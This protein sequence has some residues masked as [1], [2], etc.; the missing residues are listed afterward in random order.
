MKGIYGYTVDDV[1]DVILEKYY[2][3]CK[4][5][6]SSWHINGFRYGSNIGSTV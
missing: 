6:T 5:K 1:D 4:Y 3:G 2:V